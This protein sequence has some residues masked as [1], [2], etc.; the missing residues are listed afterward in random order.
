MRISPLP[1]LPCLVAFESAMRHGSFTKAAAE[2]HLTQSAISRQVAQLERFLGKKLFV[3]EPRALRLTVT[4]QQY[5]ERVQQMLVRCAEATEDVM[6]R[7]GQ[8]E[9]TVACS[10]GV[11]VLWLTPRLAAFRARYP[12][13]HVRLLVNDSLASLS[14]TDF[15][16]GIYY[17]RE[18]APSGM[19]SQRL[20]DEEVF[21]V[22]APSYLGDRTLSV[23]SLPKESLL[24]LEDA[25]RIWMSWPAWF[26]RHGV[27]QTRFERELVA[28]TYPVLVQMA[29]EGQGIVLAWRHMIDRCLDA[30]LLVQACQASASLG[31]GY[32]VVWP[33]DRAEPAAARVFRQWLIDESAVE[34]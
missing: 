2:L 23:S 21:P 13:F 17:L 28:N 30:G 29:I 31:G 1:P 9:L 32:Y 5:A 11:A 19:A 20:Y 15:D 22:C 3:R 27:R 4:G 10:S 7:K 16:V 33:R 6:K 26:A 25:Q 14:G 18:G 24:V 12:D 8:A 34:P